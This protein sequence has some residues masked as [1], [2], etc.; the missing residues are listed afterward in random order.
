MPLAEVREQLSSFA[1]G[2]G[3]YDTL[4]QKAGPAADGTLLVQEY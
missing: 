1:T 2:A 3:I 4:F